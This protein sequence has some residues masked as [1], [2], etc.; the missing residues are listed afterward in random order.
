[1]QFEGKKTGNIL[2]TN[3]WT[4]K[5]SYVNNETS[6]LGIW[7]LDYTNMI[8]VLIILWYRETRTIGRFLSAD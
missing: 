2:I 4:L 7:Q 1:M 8:F 3:K 5:K 6:V